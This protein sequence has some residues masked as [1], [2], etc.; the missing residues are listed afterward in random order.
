MYIS[1]CGPLAPLKAKYTYLALGPQPKPQRKMLRLPGRAG[2]LPM[3]YTQSHIG[4]VWYIVVPHKE[5]GDA[6]DRMP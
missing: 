6:V 5:K 1:A 3:R 4:A 2:L